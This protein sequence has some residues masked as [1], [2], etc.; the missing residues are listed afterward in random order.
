[1]TNFQFYRELSFLSKKIKK[2]HRLKTQFGSHLM[3]ACLNL[4]SF[5]FI[6][7]QRD[8]MYVFTPQL[9]IVHNFLDKSKGHKVN[10]ILVFHLFFCRWIF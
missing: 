6:L 5:Y 10:F 8:F 4:K 7:V 3:F 2:N 1:M 9:G